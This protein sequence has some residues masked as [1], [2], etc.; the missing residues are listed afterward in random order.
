MG[1]Y[2]SAIANKY[3]KNHCLNTYATTS[4]SVCVVYV[5]L[6]KHYGYECCCYGDKIPRCQERIRNAIETGPTVDELYRNKM[7]CVIDGS[8]I[9]HSS[10]VN[11]SS[12]GIEFKGNVDDL[13]NEMQK[14]V[15]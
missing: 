15:I 7:T 13:M 11:Y 9:S 2:T 8:S 1:Q 14:T 5:L 6:T 10:K 3:S 4:Y 12:D